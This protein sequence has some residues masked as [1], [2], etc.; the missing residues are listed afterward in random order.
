MEEKLTKNLKEIRFLC[1]FSSTAWSADKI[2]SFSLTVCRHFSVYCRS[3]SPPGRIKNLNQKFH[4]KQKQKLK[5]K[6][7]FLLQIARW[8]CLS[9]VFSPTVICVEHIFDR[10]LTFFFVAAKVDGSRGSLVGGG[11]RSVVS[12]LQF[13]QQMLES[14]PKDALI[15]LYWP[16]WLYWPPWLY[17]CIYWRSEKVWLTY[18]LTYCQLEIKKW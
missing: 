6:I 3:A 2:F 7:L 12:L 14:W 17:F 5:N 10:F 9:L 1:R 16:S 11:S 4:I 18:S 15:G 13:N 8:K